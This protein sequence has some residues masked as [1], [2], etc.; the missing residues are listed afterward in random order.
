MNLQY[1]A[2]CAVDEVTSDAIRVDNNFGVTGG[3]GGM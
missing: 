3:V 1:E 2:E